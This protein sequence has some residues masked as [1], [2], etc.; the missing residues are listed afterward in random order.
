MIIILT[1]LVA[2]VKKL[3][4]AI[5]SMCNITTTAPSTVAPP[6]VAPPT[7]L[8]TVQCNCAGRWTPVTKTV[9]GTSTIRRPAT[10]AFT[11]PSIIPS[12]ASEVLI[13]VTFQGSTGSRPQDLK[14]FMLIGSTRYEKYLMI[15]AFSAENINSDNMWFPMPPNRRIYLTN[16]V[17]NGAGAEAKLYAIGYR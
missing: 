10:T 8:P 17:G 3:K 6:T 9:I 1:G 16:S 11:I 5:D 15:K 7:P 4:A 13:Y 14:L 12:N 2:T